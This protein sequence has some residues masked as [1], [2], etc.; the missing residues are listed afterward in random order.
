MSTGTSRTEAASSSTKNVRLVLDVIADTQ[1]EA[2]EIC[3]LARS[4]L[5]HHD[6]PGRISVGGNLALLFSPH[7]VARG[8]VYEFA[9]YHLWRNPRTACAVP[10]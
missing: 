8:L 4:T 7:D 1:E 9:I 2:S 3:S 6:Y 5:L 10:D